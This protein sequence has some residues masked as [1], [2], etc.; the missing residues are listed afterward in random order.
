MTRPTIEQLEE[1][2][3]GARVRHAIFGECSVEYQ[4][5]CSA[6]GGMDLRIESE[7]GK[8]LWEEWIRDGACDDKINDE[9]YY[10]FQ[11]DTPLSEDG[12]LEILDN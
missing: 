3:E 2:P 4:G 1:L 9:R 5:S 7:E 6:P 12:I 11:E 8:D 10:V